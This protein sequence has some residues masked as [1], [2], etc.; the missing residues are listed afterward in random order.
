M[1]RLRLAAGIALVGL[2]ACSRTRDSL[3]P[4]PPGA[5]LLTPD[6]TLSIDATARFSPIEG[7]CWLLVEDAGSRYVFGLPEGFRRDG[8]TVHA[9]VRGS[10]LGSF[11][12]PGVTLDSIRMR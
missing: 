2:L 5:P 8:L 4:I 12:G 1:I 7:G 3:G 11:C 10:S 6:Q 9:V